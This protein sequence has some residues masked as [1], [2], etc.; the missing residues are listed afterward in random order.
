MKK[1][2]AFFLILA[3]C[4]MTSCK[5]YLDVAPK[6][7]LSDDQLFTT[8]TGFQQALNGVYATMAQRELYGDNLSMGFVS[9]LAQNY[10]VSGSSVP[11]VQTR[12]LNYNSDEVR[13]Y[14]TAIWS[15]SYSAIAAVNKI[16]TFI[17]EKKNILSPSGYARMK[18]EALGIRA[19]LHFEL[20]RLF[21]PTYANAPGAK[22]IPYRVSVSTMSEKPSTVSD[23]ITKVLNDLASAEDLLKN[24]DGVI[25]GSSNRQIN[26]NY[27]AVKGIQARVNIYKGNK[28]EAFKAATVVVNS[29][30]FPFVLPAAV[31]AADGKKDRLFKTELVFA[32]RVRNMKDWVD[33]E[34]FRFYGNAYMRLTRSVADFKTLYEVSSGGGTDI[35]YNYLIEDD[36]SIPFPSKFWQTFSNPLVSSLDSTRMDQLVPMIRLSEMYYIMAEAAPT[37]EEGTKWLNVVRANRSIPQLSETSTTAAGLT[38][39]ITKEYQ[40]E[41]YAE[42][43]LFYFYKRQNTLQMQF[44]TIDM[45]VSK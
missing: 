23:V 29:N 36:K 40:K 12:A 13:R 27:Y 28:E 14:T 6:S 45:L 30:A 32:L 4:G 7:S 5:K 37:P 24:T 18:G 10:M 41:F 25:S 19:Y 17:E 8:E 42:G 39:Q 11:F 16:L 15:T 3:A 1:L 22:A 38:D 26:M 44:R 21:A 2:I 20:L 9:A 35:R 43:Q 33:N 34:Y 31:S